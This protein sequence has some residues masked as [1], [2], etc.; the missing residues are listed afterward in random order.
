M[1]SLN[2]G[3]V[4]LPSTFPSANGTLFWS[5]TKKNV[6]NELFIKVANTIT[7]AQNITFQLPFSN[8]S[9]TGS[10]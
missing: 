10:V 3:D 9:S 1:F 8:F 7:T 2:R 5:V 6:T 4:Y